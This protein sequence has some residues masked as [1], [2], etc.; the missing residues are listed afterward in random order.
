ML[1]LWFQ[2]IGLLYHRSICTI[3]ATGAKHRASHAASLPLTHHGVHFLLQCRSLSPYSR[4]SRPNVSISLEHSICRNRT[5]GKADFIAFVMVWVGPHSHSR[6]GG[7]YGCVSVYHSP[8]SLYALAPRSS[9]L[10]NPR[11]PLSCSALRTLTACVKS[12]LSNSAASG[13]VGMAIVLPYVPSN[14]PQG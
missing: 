1:H 11:F 14:P 2:A 9:I 8:T 4:T 12:V 3:S 13:V 5:T 10:F 7:I 6:L